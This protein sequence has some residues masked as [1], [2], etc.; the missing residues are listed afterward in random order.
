MVVAIELVINTEDGS[1]KGK[2]LRHGHEV[3][4]G[5][6]MGRGQR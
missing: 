4:R 2:E 6:L 1:S 5:N 3:A